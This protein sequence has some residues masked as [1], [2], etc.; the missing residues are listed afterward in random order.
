MS[1]VLCLLHRYVRAEMGTLGMSLEWLKDKAEKAIKTVGETGSSLL[2]EA[3]SLGESTVKK[4]KSLTG[5]EEQ[6][7]ETKAPEAKTETKTS[8]AKVEA[9]P[10]EKKEESKSAEQKPVE[11]KDETGSAVKI[12]NTNYEDGLVADAQAIAE[13]VKKTVQDDLGFDTVKT[14]LSTI[15]D[16][17]SVPVRAATDTVSGAIGKIADFTITS[18]STRIGRSVGL[19]DTTNEN[20]KVIV[21]TDEANERMKHAAPE[22]QKKAIEATSKK[23]GDE[24]Q[25]KL[26]EARPRFGRGGF[27][28]TK[29][30]LGEVCMNNIFEQITDGDG[31]ANLTVTNEEGKEHKVTVSEE[32]LRFIAEKSNGDRPVQRVGLKEDAEYSNDFRHAI[33]NEKGERTETFTLPGSVQIKKMDR[34]G[35]LI[36]SLEKTADQTSLT[37][38]T[39]N[40]SRFKDK[41]VYRSDD[42]KAFIDN[43][44]GDMTVHTKDGYILS[45]KANESKFTVAKHEITATPDGTVV[46]NVG[47]RQA[48]FTGSDKV[49]VITGQVQENLKPGQSA[50]LLGPGFNRIVYADATLDRFEADNSW[51]LKTQGKTYRFWNEDGKTFVQHNGE[52]TELNNNDASK[53]LVAQ[54]KYD[55]NGAIEEIRDGKMFLQKTTADIN[56]GFLHLFGENGERATVKVDAHGTKVTAANNKVA[57]PSANPSDAVCTVQPAS[58]SPV[59]TVDS[60]LS[61]LRDSVAQT[62]MLT[63]NCSAPNT[64]MDLTTFEYTDGKVNVSAPVDVK[65]EFVADTDSFTLLQ[66]GPT[67]QA[68]TNVPPDLVPAAEP[69]AVVDVTKAEIRLPATKD[70]AA[71]VVGPDGIVNEKTGTKIDREGNVRLGHDGPTLHRDGSVTI[72]RD[73]HVSSSM[74]VVSGGWEST[75]AQ[76]RGP[77]SEAQAQSIAAT[78]SGKANAAYTKALGS[79]VR[80]S[81]VADLNCALSDVVSMMGLVPPGSPAYGLLMK[82]Y[83]LIMQAL[84]VAAPKAQAAERAIMA[85]ATEQQQ[86]K[87]IEMGGWGVSSTEKRAFGLV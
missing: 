25:L 38:K 16:Y 19:F 22:M 28:G 31:K 67:N 72:D 32:V 26:D 49:D 9:K 44:T 6:K 87:R 74:K 56:K 4:I 68:P 63:Q 35:N 66:N 48:M 8:D 51:V 57:D 24:E 17:A 23:G 39:E 42:F 14:V 83:G 64:N 34:D 78:V 36:T 30:T 58:T 54:L 75:A 47:G 41:T 53:H 10:A 43:K 65:R 77:V 33:T 55:T 45:K 20:V 59:T 12:E 1:I 80:W 50:L 7:T 18:N 61:M 2:N 71:I 60:M 29:E 84:S 46:K 81:E 76:Y 11:K 69:L 52:T 3:Q 85:G 13:A 27:C 40:V 5:S 21:L 37:F 79:L 86:I 70:R 15:Y 82:S 73:T 62:Q